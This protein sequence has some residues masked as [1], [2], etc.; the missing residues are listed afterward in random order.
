[1]RMNVVFYGELWK[2]L[3]F[4]ECYQFQLPY[5]SFIYLF[6]SLFAIFFLTKVPKYVLNSASDN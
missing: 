5:S 1:M 6:I 2:T 3:P 4:D